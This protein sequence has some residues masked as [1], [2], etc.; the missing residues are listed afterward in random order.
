MLDLRRVRAL[1]AVAEH[2]SLSAA[3]EA[4]SYSR[5]AISQQVAALERQIGAPVLERHARGVRLTDIGQVLVDHTNAV[6]AR[7][8]EAEAEV[9]AIADLRAGRV[10]LGSFTSAAGALLPQVF[11]LMRERHPGV[12]LS[13]KSGEP[14]ELVAALRRRDID[15]ALVFRAADDKRL[16]D[17]VDLHPLM[18][19]PLL[20]ALPEGHR[21]AARRNL[22]LADLRDEPWIQGSHGYCVD[23]LRRACWKAGFEPRIVYECDAFDAG[24]LLVG[25]GVGIALVPRMALRQLVPGVHWRDV[26]ADTPTRL[27]SA[28]VPSG[29]FT[30]PGT[31]VM[32]EILAETAA[33]YTARTT[34]RSSAA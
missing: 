8:S 26:G 9:E 10:R 6:I 19:D 27:V 5:A 2:G 1:R 30:A 16:E 15:C 20:V 28:A 31:R 22:R 24:L 33:T 29:G 12:E 13:L 32:L 7:L 18:E 17:S 3:A 34:L 23:L 21:L 11:Q 25:A 14:D 4:L